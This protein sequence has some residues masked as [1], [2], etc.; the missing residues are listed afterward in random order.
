MLRSFLLLRL[1]FFLPGLDFR[2]SSLVRPRAE[3]FGPVPPAWPQRSA[4]LPATSHSFLVDRRL[5]SHASRSEGRKVR[6]LRLGEQGW[7][8]GLEERG[9]SHVGC[10]Q[11][12]FR[13]DQES[14][15][16]L[17]GPRCWVPVLLA[18]CC[19]SGVPE[20]LKE[21]PD[22]GLGESARAAL[23]SALRWKCELEAP[24]VQLQEC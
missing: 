15:L 6:R 19:P 1:K 16:R 12:F 21:V 14:C 24:H 7:G 23:V 5:C 17:E 8:L 10:S 4:L 9:P 11:W 22:A 13:S 18:H 3:V 2:R 20:V